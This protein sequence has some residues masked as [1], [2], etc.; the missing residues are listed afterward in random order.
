MLFSEDSIS[1]LT[2]SPSVSRPT[3]PASVTPPKSRS[4]KLKRELEQ[5]ALLNRC[6]GVMSSPADTF[7][8]F[9]DYVADELRNMNLKSPDLQSKAKRQIQRIL[10]DMNEE[11]A[12]SSCIKSVTSFSPPNSIQTLQ[13]T[14]AVTEQQTKYFYDQSED[15]LQLT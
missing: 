5:Q 9:G 4:C 13:A 7:E 6:L 15:Y 2:S 10:L 11:Y 8:I 14:D 1:P 3:T 12:S